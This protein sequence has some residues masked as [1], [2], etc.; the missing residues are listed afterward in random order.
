M[1]FRFFLWTK[2]T[3]YH[4]ARVHTYHLYMHRMCICICIHTYL[5][6]CKLYHNTTSLC[7]PF[8]FISWPFL[9]LSFRFVALRGVALH[10]VALRCIACT[11]GVCVWTICKDVKLLTMQGG[12]ESHSIHC[13]TKTVVWD[14]WYRDWSSRRTCNFPIYRQW[15]PAK[16]SNRHVVQNRF[17]FCTVVAIWHYFILFWVPLHQNLLQSKDVES[18]PRTEFHDG[19]TNFSCQTFLDCLCTFDAFHISNSIRY[20]WA[21]VSLIP[22]V[23]QGGMSPSGKAFL[24]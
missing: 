19:S 23:R 8:H 18:V 10:C 24:G 15:Q 5:Y 14:L 20:F 16:P 9:F 13:P 7:T 1:P 11:Y 4:S 2:K 12:S 3:T 22:F 21:S 6:P 17:N